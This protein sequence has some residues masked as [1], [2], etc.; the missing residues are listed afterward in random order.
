MRKLLGLM[1]ILTFGF[2]FIGTVFGEED[3]AQRD[4]LTQVSTIDALLLGIYDGQMTIGELKKFGDFGLGTFNGL[5]GEMLAVDGTF[6]KITSDGSAEKIGKGIKTPFAAVTFFETD[7]SVILGSGMGYDSFQK[8]MDSLIPTQNIFYA[9]R[10]DGLF[11]EVKTRSVPRQKKPY[12]ILKEI[13]KEQPVFNF[14]YVEG[15][16]V[17]FRCPPYVRGINVP[18]YHLHFLTKDGNSG[19]HVL[20]FTIDRAV[21]KFD[22]TARYSLILP[23]DQAFYKADL[24]S[25]KQ[26]DLKKVER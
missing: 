22:K 21:L 17:G 5:D 24:D 6:Y 18:G 4:T 15:T 2:T 26:A 19:G 8:R 10:I 11:R 20:S 7:S 9:V 13:V 1:F 14:K 12:R 25:D 16:M 3:V 23:N